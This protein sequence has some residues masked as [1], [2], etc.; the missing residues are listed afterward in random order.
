MRLVLVC[1]ITLAC[2]AP[3]IAQSPQ[4]GPNPT[5]AAQLT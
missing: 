2:A 1:S 4:A 5:P 3:V